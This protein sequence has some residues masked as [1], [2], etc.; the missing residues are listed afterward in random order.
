MSIPSGG[1]KVA[2]V[3]ASSLVGEMIVQVLEERDFP[4]RE[5]HPLS[6]ARAVGGS[7]TFRGQELSLTPQMDFDFS[8]VQLAFFCAGSRVSRELAPKA[9][10]AGCVVID[11]TSAFRADADV[12]LI[13]PEVNAHALTAPLPRG[14][15]ASP[16]SAT[17][18]VAVPLAGLHAAAGVE[19]VTV[20]TY[21]SVSGAGREAV[22][23]LA[24][25][26]VALLSG[27]GLE[28][29][30][31]PARP[32]AFLCVPQIGEIKAGGFTEE[33]E[34]LRNE[35]RRILALPDLPVNATCVR[36]PVFY[37]HAAAVTVTL[38]RRISPEEARAVLAKTPGVTLFENG[39]PPSIPAEAANH[40]TV[41]VGRIRE[42]LSK[43]GSLDLWIA[44]DN[45]RKG[46]A[47]NSI[48]IAE[49][50]ARLPI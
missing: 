48:Q 14:I 49:V 36:V 6:A 15:I 9:V 46:A 31:G 50:W 41:Y 39:R 19:A 42:D 32:L 21:Q 13:L 30:R 34:K 25:Q 29:R 28:E 47:T 27:Q 3:G 1:F 22:T 16:G 24:Q 5:L 8:R 26:S 18:Q 11:S 20:A 37:G 12:P 45:V 10:A 23:E 38:R 7:V 17:V 4:V 40:D 33:E 2:V 44:V 43:A 35:T